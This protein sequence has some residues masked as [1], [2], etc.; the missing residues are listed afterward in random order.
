MNAAQKGTGRQEETASPTEYAQQKAHATAEKSAQGAV[1]GIKEQGRNAVKWLGGK[2]KTPSQTGDGPVFRGE[3]QAWNYRQHSH[4][5]THGSSV[6]PGHGGRP[7]AVRSPKASG[8]GTV[9]TARKTVKSGGNA[10]KTTQQAAATAKRTAHATAKTSQ[11]A[12][13]AAKAA[14]KASAAALKT[15]AKATISLYVNA[16]QTSL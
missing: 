15:A 14:A 5:N 7:V 13:H 16:E 8:K 12:A 1:S 2:H 6:V 9:K 3:K 11:R 4:G 10:I